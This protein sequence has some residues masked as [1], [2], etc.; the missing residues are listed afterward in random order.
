[1]AQ[2]LQPMTIGAS[3]DRAVDLLRARFLTFVGI[4]F[5]PGLT[6]LGMQL[7]SV[8]PQAGNNPSALHLVM[9]AASYLASFAFW[10]AG[11]VLG[12][13]A[14][15]ATCLVASK[16]L[17]GEDITI[18]SAFQ[19]FQS[20]GGRFVAI[21]FLQGL[22]AFWPLIFGA[23]IGGLLTVVLGSSSSYISVLVMIVFALPCVY[24]YSRYALAFPAS[25]MED[26]PVGNAIDRSIQLSEGGRWRICLG[27]ALPASLAI[28]INVGATQLI[29]LLKPMIPLL[30]HSPLAVAA[31]TGLAAFVVSL[32]F[33]PLNGII[34]TVLYYDQRIRREGYDIERLMESAG[35]T[36]PLTPP[37]GEGI[38]APAV[39]AP[40]IAPAASEGPHS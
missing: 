31:L 18:R 16:T 12:A 3:L 1:M 20:K 15:A 28:A 38:P 8:H 22:Y 14:T 34:F 26:L 40:G 32:A 30:A 33:T 37:Q 7:A 39:P 24:L 6:Q 29:E 36:A 10:L 35:M 2:P 23:I 21:T 19:R 4:A 11:L 5:I 17:F 27:F 25:A 13:I 9:V